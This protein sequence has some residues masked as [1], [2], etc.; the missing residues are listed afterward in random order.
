[1]LW[2]QSLLVS[3]IALP[4]TFSTLGWLLFTFTWVKIWI[5]KKYFTW[6]PVLLNT[7]GILITSGQILVFYSEVIVCLLSLLYH[8]EVKWIFNKQKVFLN[9]PLNV[10]PGEN[11]C[12]FFKVHTCVQKTN[13]NSGLSEFLLTFYSLTSGTQRDV[14]WHHSLDIF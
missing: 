6:V 8:L 10:A 9:F 13:R 3:V 12:F 2:S 7:I 5:W 4:N 14:H 1:M 11:F